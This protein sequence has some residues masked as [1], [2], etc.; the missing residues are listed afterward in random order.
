MEE[1]TQVRIDLHKARVSRV[2]ES[3][4]G[5]APA[6]QHQM[7]GAAADGVYVGFLL[8]AEVDLKTAHP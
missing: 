7:E 8:W 4:V 6:L 3:T 2:L 5:G 1:I